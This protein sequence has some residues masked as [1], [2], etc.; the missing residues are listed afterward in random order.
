[1]THLADAP[2]AITEEGSDLGTAHPS[3]SVVSV[4]Y[5]RPLGFGS[6]GVSGKYVRQVT[7]EE[8]GTAYAVD[9]GVQGPVGRLGEWG[10]SLANAGT[11]LS[12]GSS[13]T[14]LPLV[15]RSG[16]AGSFSLR[17]N[18]IILGSGQID[19][20]ADDHLRLR[21]GVEYGQTMGNDWKMFLRTGYASET[22][23]R[24]TLGAG[25]ERKGL[26]VNYSFSPSEDLGAAN[27]IDL[28]WR[29]GTPLA[30]EARRTALFSQARAALATG[31]VTE[32]E[33]LLAEARALSP[34]SLEGHRLQQETALQLAETMDPAAL[35]EQARRAMAKGDM[36]GAELAYRKVLL[37]RPDNTDAQKGLQKISALLSAQRTQEARAAMIRA[38]DRKIQATEG[39]ARDAM[40][41]GEWEPALGHWRE[42]LALDPENATAG[43][44]IIRCQKALVQET[45]SRTLET[46]ARRAEGLKKYEEGR[47]VYR[48]GNLSKAKAL[49]EEAVRL[50]PTNKTYRRALD[51]ARQEAA[52]RAP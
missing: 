36:A 50:D 35:L 9:A 30:Q 41:R 51:R 2:L 28:R 24:F 1:M 52:P 12:L 27:R 22:A 32:A 34:R 11:E 43:T 29:F 42:L 21:A 7:F 3:E 49:F 23:A 19:I 13:N 6:F 47:T 33:D 4:G 17:R 37:V 39:R 14:K 16:V 10:V 38:K 15:I 31:Q 48:E 25:I 45:Q 40:K 44:E 18:G 46:E 5:A 20:P 8:V 26:A